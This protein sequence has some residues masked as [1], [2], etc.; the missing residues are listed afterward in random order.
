MS[1]FFFSCLF[2]GAVCGMV[3]GLMD[4]ADSGA[5]PAAII[6]AV[7]NCRILD[8]LMRILLLSL[9]IILHVYWLRSLENHE[10]TVQDSTD[11]RPFSS[12]DER[13]SERGKV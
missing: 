7:A 12:G 3:G 10:K 11:F 8:D 4:S 2:I 13:G 9:D 6:K 5:M 1:R